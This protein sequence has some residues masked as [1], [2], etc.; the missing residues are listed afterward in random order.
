MFNVGRSMFDVHLVLQA[1]IEMPPLY[2]SGGRGDLNNE[3]KN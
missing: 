1:L 2:L 3:R